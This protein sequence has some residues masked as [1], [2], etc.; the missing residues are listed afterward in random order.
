VGADGA[1]DEIKMGGRRCEG[2]D[3]RGAPNRM[4]CCF[5]V[6]EGA[7]S[8]SASLACFVCCAC[9]A[10]LGPRPQSKVFGCPCCTGAHPAVCG[11]Q[12]SASLAA[13]VQPIVCATQC[14]PKCYLLSLNGISV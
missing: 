14:M 12:C 2:K 9:M 10:M 5:W 4:G 13:E 8:Q 11:L 7:K 6:S 3:G 1:E